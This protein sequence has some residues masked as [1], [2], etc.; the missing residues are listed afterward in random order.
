[1]KVA[2]R[3]LEFI[4]QS[5]GVDLSTLIMAT[6]F[7]YDLDDSLEIVQVV[8]LCEEEFDIIIEKGE[9]EQCETVGQLVKLVKEKLRQKPL[10]PRAYEL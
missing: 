10:W 4:A 8:M 1:M 2:D 7:D 5:Y 3:V 6:Q 9:A